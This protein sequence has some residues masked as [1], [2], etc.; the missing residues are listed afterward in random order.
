LCARACKGELTEAATRPEYVERT[1]NVTADVLGSGLDFLTALCKRRGKLPPSAALSS[2]QARSGDSPSCAAAGRLL[3]GGEPD[4]RSVALQVLYDLQRG[5]IPYFIPP[6]KRE[7]EAA[8]AAGE[9]GEED[10]LDEQVSLK[11]HGV[12]VEHQ[13]FAELPQHNFDSSGKAAGGGGHEAAAWADLDLE[14]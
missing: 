2:R 11:R 9:E 4:L 5:R 6:A 1:Y 8:A 13:D 7:G 12:R 3:K 10:P 14:D